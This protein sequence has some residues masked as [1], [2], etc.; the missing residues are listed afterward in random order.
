M[1]TSQAS[2]PEQ[3]YREPLPALRLLFVVGSVLVILGGTQ[4]FVF[5]ERTDEFFAWTIAAPLTAAVDGAFFYTGFILLFTS[6]RAATW[7][8]VRKVAYAVLIVA[9]VKL[10]ATLLDLPLFHFDDGPFLARFGAWAWL[11]VYIVIPVGLS[12]LIVMQRRLPGR[13]PAPGPPLPRL[14]VAAFA[15]IAVVMLAIGAVALLSSSTTIDIWPWPLTPLTSHAL[16]A[17]FLGVGALAAMT[18]REND[19]ARSQAVML[20]SAV[21]GVM[22]AVALA[23]YGGDVDFGEPIA[24]VLVGLIVTL[25]LAGAGGLVARP[26]PPDQPS[27]SRRAR[28]KEAT[29]R[30]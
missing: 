17:W 30:S 2:A 25:V 15:L 4:L 5:S 23:R 27:A 14:L 24:W 29:T 26:Q 12:V 16:S 10:L 8:D 20:G 21:L 22:L 18:V 3:T 1:A 28:E 6:W 13:D 19:M 7:A 11:I 9:T